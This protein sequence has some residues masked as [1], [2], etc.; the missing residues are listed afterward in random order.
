MTGKKVQGQV[1]DYHG[2]VIEQLVGFEGTSRS[3]VVARIIGF[4]I[5]DNVDH[6]RDLGIT[7]NEWRT[8]KT[9]TDRPNVVPYSKSAAERR[10]AKGDEE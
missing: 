10:R 2:F 9:S 5:R 7:P 3:D 8:Q 6:L 1:P 4:W